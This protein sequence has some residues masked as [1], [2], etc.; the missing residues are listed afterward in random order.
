MHLKL[1]FIVFLSFFGLLA[2]FFWFAPV[3][4]EDTHDSN[5][6]NNIISQ[7]ND[8]DKENLKLLVDSLNNPEKVKELISLIESLILIEKINEEKVENKIS[9]IRK[10][11]VNLS[12]LD[13][14]KL[15]ISIIK[16][17]VIIIFAF[18]IIRL[19]GLGL[20][21]ILLSKGDID[22]GTGNFS[23][24]SR[25][26]IF[27]RKIIT[28]SVFLLSVLLILKVFNV[29]IIDYF[30]SDFG[31]QLASRVFTI[32]FVIILSLILWSITSSAIDKVLIKANLDRSGNR[33]R[34]LLPLAR[35][36]ILILI[37]ITS[38]IIILSEIGVNIAPLLA[39][40]GI[41]GL[42]IGFGAQTL[43]KDIIT[44]AFIV[45]ENTLAIGDVIEVANHSGVVEGMTIRTIKLRDLKGRIHTIPFSSVDTI[46][47][48][49][50][51]YSYVVSEIGVSYREDTDEVINIIKNVF[52]SLRN[53]E[54]FKLNIID[55]LEVMGLERFDDSA[56]II[57]IRIKTKPGLQWS[58][59][60]EFNR[61][62]KYA[63]DKNS[64]EI[65][66]P[67]NT[68]YFG[69]DKKGESPPVNINIKKSE[70]T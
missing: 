39:G 5:S 22:A 53:D 55:E 10:L 41:I 20:N 48:M 60:R 42:A 12:N 69:E 70:K 15:V 54:T 2:C 59:N 47:N 18:F 68:I 6:T 28:F 66:Y 29:D 64:I 50:R 45:F 49:T 32:V 25:Y 33:I 67:H 57:K 23:T 62:I 65:P 1:K 63:F 34:T 13:I 21:K 35:N 26:I 51:D 43:V 19:F 61:R 9:L 30:K 58:I 27:A 31:F 7:L 14:E 56:V 11:N 3:Y 52:D 37:I 38:T 44:G 4:A 8:N 16:S 24:N 40:A 17:L 36:A 46:V